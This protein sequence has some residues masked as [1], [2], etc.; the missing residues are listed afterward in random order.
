M[1]IYCPQHQKDFLAP[2]KNP[3]RCENKFHVLGELDFEGRGLEPGAPR[4]EYCCNCEHY[5]PLGIDHI[6]S[7]HC[8]V[9]ARLISQRYLCDRCYTISLESPTPAEV[10]NFRL[11]PEGA[12]QPSCP[13]CI[14]SPTGT[15]Q[16]HQCNSLNISFTTALAWCPACQEF[17]GDVP[18]F[19][20]PAGAYLDRVKGY[21]SARIDYETNMLVE[22]DEGEYALVPNGNGTNQSI[23]LPRLARFASKRDYYDNY[24]DFYH[25]AAPS[26]GEVIVVY[27]AVAE[28]VEGWW[29]LQQT[30]KL[31]VLGDAFGEAAESPRPDALPV[32][33]RAS[34]ERAEGEQAGP[35]VTCPNCGTVGSSGNAFCW[36]C[37]KM[38][39]P[40][41]DHPKDSSQNFSAATAEPESAASSKSDLVANLTSIFTPLLGVRASAAGEMMRML[42]IAG[43]VA[44]ISF[45]I[46]VLIR[47]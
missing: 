25:C 27:P 30:G 3:I 40:D 13:G 33:R 20:F 34:K 36:H 38:I 45:L 28:K 44:V 8:P 6:A 29:A 41:Q 42:I 21:K 17:I 4:W 32:E 11:S 9:C 18:P 15:L 22:D 2:R 19:P 5:W 16:E 26:A 47:L 23:V 12:P 24:Q 31:E 1:I 43:A 46:V 37:G 35:E 39:S 10:R 14:E 7:T